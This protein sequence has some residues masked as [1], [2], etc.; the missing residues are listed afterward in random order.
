MPAVTTPSNKTFDASEKNPAACAVIL[1]HPEDDCNFA[2]RSFGAK[3][4]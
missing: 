3:T 1:L 4:M 2:S